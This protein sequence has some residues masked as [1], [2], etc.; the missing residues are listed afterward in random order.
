MK[1]LPPDHVVV[2]RGGSLT[3]DYARKFPQYDGCLSAFGQTPKTRP[4]P[5]RHCVV[6]ARTKVDRD[7]GRTREA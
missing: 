5:P 3:G 7:A 1:D 4:K 6:G 2:W